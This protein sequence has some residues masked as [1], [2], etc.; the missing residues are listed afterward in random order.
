MSGYKALEG[1][2][3]LDFTK[4][5]AGPSSCALL[6]DF[7]ADV[8]KVEVPGK[9]DDSRTYGPLVNGESVYYMNV[10]RGKR[11][12]TLDLKSEKGREIFLKLVQWA[13]VFV[14]SNR[15]GTMDKLG[16]GYDV[17][18][19]VNPRLIYGSISGFGATGPY[20]MRPGYDI[21]AQAMGGMMSITGQQGDPPTRSGNA[22]GDVLAG[23]NMVIGILLALE[24][25]E[26]SGRGQRVDISLTDSII[27][28][29]EQAWQRYFVLGKVPTRHGNS[30]DAVA[31]YDSFEAKDGY[32]VIGC[33]NQRLFEILCR[34]LLKKPELIDDPRFATNILRVENNLALKEIIEEWT[35]TETVADITDRCLAAGIAAGPILDVT[36]ISKDEHFT[37]ARAMWS[38]VE[39][40]VSGTVRLNN[41]PIKLSE[42]GGEIRSAGPLLGQHNEEV[43]TELGYTAE[44]IA[45]FKAD[46]VL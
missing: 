22:L 33:G 19:K 18:S 45:R 13:D 46:G 7:G 44:E 35:R 6:A 17:L 37:K 1:L 10:N 36:Q 42:S 26:R 39:H 40:P 38:D 2:K 32:A 5:L 28:S 11:G 31:P 15:P 14:E 43:L 41:T 12:I 29:L 25:R 20:A 30:Y 34:D 23:M 9:G 21:I 8:I 24:A 4:V 27:A 3:V 16:L